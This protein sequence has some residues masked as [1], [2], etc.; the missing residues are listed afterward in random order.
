[1][2]ALCFLLALALLMLL[3]AFLTVRGL[4][5]GYA[6][7]NLDAAWLM[8]RLGPARGLLTYQAGWLTAFA[9]GVALFPTQ[10]IHLAIACGESARSAALN[11]RL[12]RKRSSPAKP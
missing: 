9:A 6:E 10:W 11:A 7:Q 5:G 8:R 2:V 3:D 1:M 4:A 12:L